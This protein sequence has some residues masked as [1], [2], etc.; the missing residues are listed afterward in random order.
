MHKRII[1]F[2]LIILIFTLH[3]SYAGEAFE[4]TMKTPINKNPPLKTPGSPKV[5]IIVSS[6]ET[7]LSMPRHGKITLSLP[8]NWIIEVKDES[9]KVSPFLEINSPSG[10][11]FSILVTPFWENSIKQP[12]TLDYIKNI[13]IDNA[14]SLSTTSVEGTY[15]LTKIEGPQLQGYYYQFTDK[16]PKPHEWACIT[17]G[18]AGSDKIM[19]LFTIFTKSKDS[20]EVTQGLSLVKSI[21][22]N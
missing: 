14:N 3:S 4:L 8:K 18:T 16:A 20:L 9:D 11:D 19:I 1:V 2:L 10:E 13:S 5:D 7:T 12:L 15:T 17:Q 6:T 22:F 21:T